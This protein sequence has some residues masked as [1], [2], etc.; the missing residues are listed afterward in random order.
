MGILKCFRILFINVIILTIL[1][2][3]LLIA[4][5]TIWTV[6]DDLKDLPNADFTK[7]LDAVDAAK[8]GDTVVVYP[9][10]YY[11]STINLDKRLNLTGVGHPTIVVKSYPIFILRADGCIIEGFKLEGRDPFAYLIHLKS[12]ENII[13]DNIL[14]GG[15][16]YSTGIKIESDKNTIKNNTIKDCGLNGININGNK[17]HVEHNAINCGITNPLL[18]W[19]TG[20]DINGDANTVYLNKV[21]S[22]KLD[23][24]SINGNGNIILGNEISGS[25][26]GFYLNGEFNIIYLNSI[27][28]MEKPFACSDSNN[29]IYL[30]NFFAK[31]KQYYSPGNTLNSWNTSRKIEYVYEGRSFKG[32]LGNYWSYYVGRDENNDGVEDIPFRIDKNKDYYPLMKPVWNYSIPHK[33]HELLETPIPMGLKGIQ[34]EG[35]K[36]PG[37][38]A[39]LLIFGS[40]VGLCLL[41]ITKSGR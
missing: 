6:D 25:D 23:G 37:F 32:Y 27:Y 15:G 18:S 34:E 2:G 16:K 26:K 29:K 17:N 40:S 19:G 7:I 38:E 1:V 22:C 3:N 5:A 24:I 4:E 9:G 35:E 11:E 36:S 21:V 39:V 14:I 30:N 28:F 8:N 33:I 20:I 13:K 31:S 41:R 10:T 12:N